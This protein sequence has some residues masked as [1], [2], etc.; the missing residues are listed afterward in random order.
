[1]PFMIM[2]ILN[3]V[4]EMPHILEAWEAAG[5][6]GITIL[7]SSG[8]NRVGKT[9]FRDDLP[10]IPSLVDV[11]EGNSV[12]HKTL[13]MIVKTQEE[14]DRFVEVARGIVGDFDHRHTGLLCVL[15]V[16]QVYGINRHDHPEH[17]G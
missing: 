10:L 15:P 7:D 9:S 8:M 6:P 17:H 2:Y 13:L 16:A 14:V 3:G 11:L 5:A 1:M 12:E 4:E